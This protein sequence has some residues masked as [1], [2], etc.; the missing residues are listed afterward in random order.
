MNRRAQLARASLA[1][2]RRGMPA[3]PALVQ[4]L[5]LVAA[6]LAE[7]RQLGERTADVCCP[8]RPMTKGIAMADLAVT[9]QECNH[10]SAI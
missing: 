10:A 3:D 4:Q 1:A 2:A 6:R 5:L 8:R 7:L 9:T